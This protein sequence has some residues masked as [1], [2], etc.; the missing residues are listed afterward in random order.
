MET[1]ENSIRTIL[2][3]LY[4]YPYLD[5][6][7]EQTKK[8]IISINISVKEY[9]GSKRSYNILNNQEKAL[10]DSQEL[11]ELYFWKNN[12]DVIMNYVQIKFPKLYSYV[13]LR[14]FNRADRK[15]VKKIL[16]ISFEKQEK[17]DRKL[18]RLIDK[19]LYEKDLVV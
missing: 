6:I 9:R 13:E 11:K 17:L 3:Y 2:Q 10:A 1:D 16:N 15:E 18:F 5:E 19:H 12:F 7:I 8:D 4:D 14:F